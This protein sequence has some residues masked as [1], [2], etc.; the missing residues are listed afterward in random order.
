MENELRNMIG[1]D[2]FS[3]Y[4]LT[5][6]KYTNIMNEMVD[7]LL[8]LTIPMLYQLDEQ[9]TRILRK[10]LGIYTD[11]ESIGVAIIAN[12]ENKTVPAIR[13]RLKNCYLQLKIN[14]FSKIYKYT[15]NYEE[16]KNI[17]IKDIFNSSEDRYHLEKL[18]IYTFYDLI[19]IKE[20]EI[21]N[22][23]NC[24]FNDPLKNIKLTPTYIRISKI[25]FELGLWVNNKPKK[26]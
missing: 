23:F 18:N 1:K 16:L 4:W 12:S 17:D 20:Q 3:Y 24:F 25:M 5:E 14:Y 15:T 11:G 7:E 19:F 8:D 26:K 6:H 13:K 21:L 10:H 22:Y 9:N 2:L